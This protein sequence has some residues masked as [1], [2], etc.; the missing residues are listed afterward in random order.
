MLLAGITAEAVVFSWAG[1]DGRR[2]EAAMKFASLGV[3]GPP[4][5]GLPS[6]FAAFSCST[7]AE[8]PAA[9]NAKPTIMLK[10][11]FIKGNSTVPPRFRGVDPD[12]LQ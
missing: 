10:T 4:S 7:L 2:V 5:V 8:T 11:F 9:S 3:D 6:G 12:W 1:N